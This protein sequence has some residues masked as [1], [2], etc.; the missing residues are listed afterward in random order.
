MEPSAVTDDA[1]SFKSDCSSSKIVPGIA[2]R[3]KN[4]KK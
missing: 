3:R 2:V 1:V 4:E